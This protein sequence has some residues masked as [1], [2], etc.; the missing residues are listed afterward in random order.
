MVATDG[1]PGATDDEPG[2]T[3]GEFPATVLSWSGGKDA[4]FALRE[5]QQSKTDVIEL[6]T[7]VSA[8]TGRSS[9]HGVHRDLYERQAEAL[10][11]PIRF[12]EIPDDA[13]N[14]EYEAAMAEATAEYERRGVE[15]IAFADLYLED[16]RTYRE[17][18]LSESGVEGYWPI[19]GRDTTDVI[20][21]F[22]DAG[23]EATVVAV[24]DDAL[25]ASFAGRPLDEAFLADLPED[26]DSCG[27][28]GE[29]HTFVH[30]GPVFDSPV[31]VRTG[32]VV[33]TEPGHGGM[34]VHQCE[35]RAAE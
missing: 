28:N 23:F 17:N 26:V 33:T 16:I 30:D 7:T 2:A 27:E 14:E 5:M 18:R 8:E 13:S 20:R 11:L 21:E 35:I 1:E 34:V 3:D 25:D 31:P 29:F 32:D 10:G 6:L 22:L 19:W 12:V 4:S 24:E 9:M 15:Q